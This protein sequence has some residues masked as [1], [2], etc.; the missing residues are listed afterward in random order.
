VL[1]ALVATV[2]GRAGLAGQQTAQGPLMSL[3]EAQATTKASSALVRMVEAQ[4]DQARLEEAET[5]R[6]ADAIAAD[7]VES[8]EVA[9]LKYLQPARAT[10]ERELAEARLVATA[11]NLDLQVA[12]VYIGSLQA[13]RFLDL[14]LEAAAR[15]RDQVELTQRMEFAGMVA[16]KDVLD[17]M[18]R[19]AE[20]RVG[21]IA[22]RK[23]TELTRLSLLRLLGDGR[24]EAP[25]PDPSTL[26]RLQDGFGVESWVAQALEQRYEVLR[27]DGYVRLAELNLDLARRYPSGGLPITSLPDIPGLPEIPPGYFEPSWERSERY[28]IPLAEAQLREATAG[29]QLQLEEVEFQAR[30]AHL[31]V[32]EARERAALLGAAVDAA[33][34]GFR[35]ARLRYEA[36]VAINLEVLG[37]ELLWRQAQTEQVRAEF[38]C[39]MAMAQLIQASSPGSR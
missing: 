16:R 33:A 19:E 3:T 23:A 32:L 34:E 18:A 28:T 14:A 22:A 29:R 6:T 30:S 11:H 4:V 1:V 35:L 17:A 38:E 12:L 9:V 25:R 39:Q 26:G 13:G 37:A 10:L 8:Y 24:A 15:A 36:G 31:D 27:V 2:V 21:V 5:Q 7:S 20:A